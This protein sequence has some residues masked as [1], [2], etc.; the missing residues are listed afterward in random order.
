M[1]AITIQRQGAPVAANVKLVDTWANPAPGRGEALIRTEAS[2]LNHLDLWVGRGLP[3]LSLEYPRIGGSDG[4]GIVE[5][6]GEGVDPS[7]IGRRVVLNAAI[8]QPSP[9]LPDQSPA[10]PDVQL[11]GEHTNGTLAEKFIAP[12]ANV[13]DVGDV[14]PADAA[15]FA[16]TH[17][18]AWRMMWTRARIQ[19]GQTALVTG[20]GGGVALAALNIA[21][22]FGCRTIVTSRHQSKLDRAKE[23][24]AD[25][26]VLDD[27]A[28]WSKEVRSI[29]NK[30]GVDV[31]IDSIGK[32]VHLSCIKSLARGGTFVT[33]GTTTGFDPATDLARVFWNQLNILGSTMGDMDEFREVIALLRRPTATAMKPVIDSTF[34]PDDGAKAFARL[35]SG[36]QFGKI[37]I[38]W[39]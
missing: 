5:Q 18:T 28:D 26:G 17:L 39:K 33:C 34:T 22:H 3:G 14:D 37:V 15:A 31:C 32:A 21:L 23:L 11:I 36:E 30:R 7:W 6:A 8:P 13:L 35:E 16:L 24:G 9:A 10:S 2:A 20:I 25:Y 38:R 12:V 19:P 29:T 1:R 4:C 27:G